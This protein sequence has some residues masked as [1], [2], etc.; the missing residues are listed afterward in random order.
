MVVVIVNSTVKINQSIICVV[1]LEIPQYG[2]IYYG[3]NL[4]VLALLSPPQQPADLQPEL[5]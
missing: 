1:S 4:P 5:R 3:H 2:L